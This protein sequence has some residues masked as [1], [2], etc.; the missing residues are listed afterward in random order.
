MAFDK[1][2]FKMILFL[3][4]IYSLT[5]EVKS[6]CLSRNMTTINH[7]NMNTLDNDR[8]IL[9]ASNGITVYNKDMTIIYFHYNFPSNITIEGNNDISKTNIKQ[10]SEENRGKYIICLIQNYFLILDENGELYYETFLNL[11]PKNAISLI[12][13]KYENS[14]YYFIIAYSDS[15]VNIYYYNFEIINKSNVILSS[16]YATIYKPIIDETLRG[17]GNEGLSCE[18]IISSDSKKSLTC[19]IK[20]LDVNLLTSNTFN[21]DSNFTLLLEPAI[22]SFGSKDIKLISS[23]SD[24]KKENILVCYNTPSQYTECYIY[25]IKD[26][27]FTTKENYTISPCS[28]NAGAIH[29]Y[30]F[31]KNNQFVAACISNNKDYNLLII[32]EDF[33]KATLSTNNLGDG[34]YGVYSFSVIPSTTVGEYSVLLQSNC[35]SGVYVRQYQITEDEKNCIEYPEI[36]TD[37]SSSTPTPT[38]EIKATDKIIPVTTTTIKE[39]TPTTTIKET[40]PT[41]IKETTPTPTTTIEVVNPPETSEIKC[42]LTQCSECNNES[43]NQ[44]KCI[45]CAQSYYPI[46]TEYISQKNGDTK[47][48]ECFD[49]KTKPNNYFFNKDYYEACFESCYNCTELGDNF[50][51]KCLSC[52]FNFIRNQDV[53]D[54][55]NCAYKCDF[56]YYY[57]DFN[58]YKCTEKNYCP[59]DN[60]LLIKEKGRCINDCRKDNKY[61]WQYNGECILKCPNDTIENTTTYICENEKNKCSLSRKEIKFYNNSDVEGYIEQMAKAYSQEF[62]YTKDHITN[63]KTKNIDMILYKNVECIDELQLSIPQ[64]DFSSCMAKLNVTMDNL[65][66]AVIDLLSGDNPQTTYCLFDSI[67]GKRINTT[68]CKDVVI[69]IKENVFKYLSDN[70]T[71]IFLA[72]QNINVFNLSDTFF[73]DI[74]LQWISPNGKDAT[75]Q[76]R[77]LEYH[78]NI[79]LCDEG[80]IS[81]GVNLT[82]FLALCEC[83]YKDLFEKIEWDFLKDNIII[84]E[85]IE[86]FKEIAEAINL[87]VLTCYKTIFDMK[88]FKKC[89]GG[90]IFFGLIFFQILFTLVY[91]FSGIN[92]PIVFINHLSNDYIAYY[93]SISDNNNNNGKNIKINDKSSKINI[94][95][96]NNFSLIKKNAPPKKTSLK[97][98]YKLKSTLRDSSATPDSFNKKNNSIYLLKSG[99]KDSM[100][101]KSSTKLNKYKLNNTKKKKNYKR[102][103]VVPN[104]KI[105]QSLKKQQTKSTNINIEEYLEKPF[106]EMEFEDVLILDKR[107]F[108]EFLGERIVDTQMIIN[109]F[110][111]NDNILPKSLK[112]ILFIVRLSLCFTINGLFFNEKYISSVFNLTEDEKFFSF[113]ERSINRFIYTY[114]SGGI[115]S[116][117]IECFFIEEKKIKKILIR[118]KHTPFKVKHELFIIIQKIKVRNRN[119]VILSYFVTIIS[120]FYVSC[121]NNVYNYTQR[122]WIK[123]SIFFFILIQFSYILFSFIET[124]IRFISFKCKSE[125]IYE[126]S[127]IFS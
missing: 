45:S 9:I 11:S 52:A 19:F 105:L 13:Y 102:K 48:I 31:P 28:S 106:E 113:V 85:F 87:E 50:D 80:C 63:Y 61:Q 36:P 38:S 34:C 32:S 4:V 110:F 64:I 47:Y 44:K 43:K 71:A 117:F 82:T 10:F 35:D 6:K 79:T 56:Y 14:K 101:K 5:K 121:F 114:L 58:Q 37:L 62:F 109:Y 115:I 26:N 112:A 27:N 108:C 90:F 125:N 59:E 92:E 40:T 119:F 124:V 127:T 107:T 91:F 42:N 41:T 12:P 49:D 118:L 86:N 104:S 70:I 20:V 69:E 75:L 97:A 23:A 83:K 2:N 100:T 3:F 1:I 72:K 94:K 95:Q 33:S 99:S 89:I 15:G 84:N 25:N 68:I 67:T 98:K 46:K 7:P 74:C 54:K 81:K 78:P 22:I 93:E 120:W 16:I 88:Y 76:D 126:L 57:D 77:I 122:E 51:N 66:I 73:T 103:T 55:Y 65:I 30:F 24:T 29:T 111:I 96:K 17:I 60:Y 123:S 21:P 39:T 116:F 53:P 8:K 18:I